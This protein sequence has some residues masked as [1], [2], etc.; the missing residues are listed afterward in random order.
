MLFKPNL[1]HAVH[2]FQ[3]VPILLI[4]PSN[5]PVL[6]QALVRA[7]HAGVFPSAAVRPGTLRTGRRSFLHVQ[8][9]WRPAAQRG[10]SLVEVAIVTAIVLLIAILGVPTIGTYV[11]EN[12]VPK[13]G[14][15]LQRFVLR[16]QVNAQG[17]GATPYAGIDNDT[18]AHAL[19][20]SSVFDLADRGAAQTIT[21][22]LSRGGAS[23]SG[24]VTL[25]P[26]ALG[27][28][29]MGSGFSITLTQVS[30]AAC[31]GLASVMQGVS[32][33]IRVEGRNGSVTVKDDSATQPVRYSA[34]RTANACSEG[35][36][37]TFVF[38]AR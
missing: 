12:K 23:T 20:E 16:T 37:N 26:V 5:F 11:I 7:A 38:I 18:L 28:A 17:T 33:V 34:A 6:A 4:H 29:G 19:R 21:H 9:G 3:Q 27:G 22:G 35:D 31:P 32:S 14:E 10:F 25:A 13:V 24:A 8:A 1:P 2:S 30:D 15:A 36:V